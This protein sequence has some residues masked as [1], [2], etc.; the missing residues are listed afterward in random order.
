MK[1]I[2]LIT[3]F[4]L[5]SVLSIQV[6]AQETII[7]DI[8]YTQLEEYIALAKANYPRSKIM[9]LAERKAKG[10]AP[11]EAV[12]I[13]DVVNVSY[14]YRPES[15]SAINPENPYVFNG[16]QFGIGMSLGALAEKPLK[17]KQAKLDYEI[18]KLETLD[19]E[20]ILSLEVKNRYYLYILQLKELKLRTQAAQDA[21]VLSDDISLR[22]ERGQVELDSYSTAK[23]ALN[24]AL[25]TKIQ[26]EVAYLFSKDQ[27]EEIIGKKLSN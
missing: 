20:K 5:T 15:K 24:D 22:F 25:S 4:I 6:S 18:A 11:I 27:L 19:Y 13:L 9:A 21:Q 26:T 17:I 10:L 8:N 2:L 3:A 16:V 1:Y 12:S 14:Y 23:S 7:D